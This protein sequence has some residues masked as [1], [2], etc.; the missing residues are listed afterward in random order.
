[1]S[2]EGF[3][4]HLS[5]RHQIDGRQV[6]GSGEARVRVID[7]ATK[8]SEGL[9]TFRHT[10]LAM[11]DSAAHAH[12]FWWFPYGDAEAFPGPRER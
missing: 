12:D 10:K 4:Q 6:P 5:G 8:G 11:I 3:F 9:D 1:M 2:V 7:P